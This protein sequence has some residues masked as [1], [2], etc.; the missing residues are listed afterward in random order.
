MKS[1]KQRAI[2]T[3]RA[4]AEGREKY[5]DRL[6]FRHLRKLP[7]GVR[8]VKLDRG[9]EDGQLVLYV[10]YMLNGTLVRDKIPVPQ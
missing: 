10:D 5:I 4:T 3:L 6:I 1:L 2:E 9:R 8:E 7:R